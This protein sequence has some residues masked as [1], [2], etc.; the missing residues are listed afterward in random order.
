MSLNTEL[1]S[2]VHNRLLGADGGRSSTSDGHD[3]P[4]ITT[5]VSD[6]LHIRS[7]ML[8]ADMLFPCGEFSSVA[9]PAVYCLLRSH[10]ENM[11]DLT[12]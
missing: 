1:G 5:A 10:P 8:C 12:L 6:S 9:L 11:S 7:L 4:G 2:F 3:G